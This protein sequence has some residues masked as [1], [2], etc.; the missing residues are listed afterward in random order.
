[1]TGISLRRFLALAAIALAPIVS[2]T[3]SCKDEILP[4]KGQLMLVITTNLAPPKDFDTLHLRIVEDGSTTP[5][6]EVDYALGGSQ[7]VKLPATLGV[8]AGSDPN[9]TVRITV[10]ARRGATVRVSRDA[11]ARV[12]TD[13]IASLPLPID[14]LCIDTPCP[15]DASGGVQTC[16]AGTCQTAAVATDTL[17]DF[18]PGDV[19]GGGTGHGDGVC[20][21]TL[22]CFTNGHTGVVRTSDCSIDREV[23]SGFGFNIAVVRPPDSDGICGSNACLLPLERDPFTGPIVTGWRE[24]GERAV[25]PPII[26]ERSLPVLVTTSCPT[27]SAPT[28]GPWSATGSARDLGDAAIP[29]DASSGFSGGE[30]GALS[31]LPRSVA[32]LDEDTRLGFVTGT[33]TIGHATDE[34]SVT[35]YKLYWA[36][37]PTKKLDL[38]ATLPRTGADVTHALA[39]PVLPGGTHLLAFSTTAMGEL[40]P[41]VNVGPIDNYTRMTAIT[42]NNIAV[43]LPI[44]LADAKTSSLLVVGLDKTASRN[45]PAL[46]HCKLDASGCVYTDISAGAPAGTAGAHFGATIDPVNQKLLVLSDNQNVG[47]PKLFRCNTDGTACTVTTLGV[48]SAHTLACRIP[49]MVD[50]VNQKLLAIVSSTGSSLTTLLRCGLDGQGCT[51]QVING[52]TNTC[53]TA[54]ISNTDAK[55]LVVEGGIATG[56]PT[57]HRCELDGTNCEVLDISGT[58]PAVVQSA[59]AAIDTENQKLVVLTHQTNQLLMFYYRCNLDGTGCVSR[60]LGVVDNAFRVPQDPSLL[61]DFTHHRLFAFAYA[62][63]SSVGGLVRCDLDGT[64]CS[65]TVTLVSA[66]TKP[67]G[68]LFGNKLYSVSPSS[69][70]IDLVTLSTY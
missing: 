37:G 42:A 13:R 3:T 61:L 38:I 29:F 28:C 70:G 19:F 26:C 1:M 44:V 5:L 63:M 9:K 52:N 22:A 69:S 43:D 30:A 18:T 40:S 2:L 21:D 59:S 23:Q 17:P 31:P 25:L 65:N 60:D 8:V 54:V 12:P 68:L 58:S 16:I 48:P 7:A 55:L 33:V 32:F 53:A 62:S 10:E 24:V 41:G 57:L 49:L 15:S 11:V 46:V 36:D 56:K 64:N 27:K 14:G 51:Y 67:N 39:G 50:T 4:V 35:G 20:F 66:G 34:S 6:H 47:S 45:V